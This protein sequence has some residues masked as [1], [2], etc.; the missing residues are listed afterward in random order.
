MAFR[1]GHIGIYVSARAMR[2]VPPAIGAWLRERSQSKSG[3][4]K[5]ASGQRKR[6]RK[7]PSLKSATA[8]RSTKTP[9]R[10]RKKTKG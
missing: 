7:D 3:K 10:S 4:G 1:G 5:R 2:D 9:H 6:A 8:T